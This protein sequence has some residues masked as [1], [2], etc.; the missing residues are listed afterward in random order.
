MLHRPHHGNLSQG[1]VNGLHLH[2]RPNLPL[3]ADHSIG[4]LQQVN[5]GPGAV[6]VLAGLVVQEEPGE[7]EEETD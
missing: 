5:H 4:L 3:Q 2:L 6:P 7:D 1:H